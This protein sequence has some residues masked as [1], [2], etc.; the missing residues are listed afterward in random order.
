MYQYIEFTTPRP[1][2]E[3]IEYWAT[4]LQEGDIIQI[5]YDRNGDGIEEATHS[6]I[7]QKVSEDEILMAQHSGN[8]L[9]KN[10]K[11]TLEKSDMAT[12]SIVILRIS[13][14]E[15]EE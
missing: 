10:L 1:I 12:K 9:D 15:Q 4:I 3:N 13:N 5:K 14:Y 7:V 8:M 2:S 6:M 11:E